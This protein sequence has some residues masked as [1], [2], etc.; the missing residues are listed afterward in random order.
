M[1]KHILLPIDK[2]NYLLQCA[3]GEKDED[4]PKL[5]IDQIVEIIPKR[6]Q[7]KARVLLQLVQNHIQCD[8]TGQV[9]VHGDTIQGSHISDVVKYAVV[10]SFAKAQAPPGS[11]EFA[12]VLTVINAPKSL[13]IN[14]QPSSHGWHA[15]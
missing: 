12:A 7:H 13:V 9:V 14:K 1:K 8:S 11:K 6:W 3:A 10:P 2:Y 15:L 4:P 5:T